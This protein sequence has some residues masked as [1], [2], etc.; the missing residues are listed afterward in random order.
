MRAPDHLNALRAFEAAARH[1]SFALAAEELNVTPAAVGQLVRRLEEVLG[2][3]LFHRSQSGPARLMPTETAERCGSTKNTS[4]AC[5]VSA[6]K[7]SSPKSS[8]REPNT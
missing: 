2:I 1:A 5:G 4:R 3:E 6:R 8:D 7:R